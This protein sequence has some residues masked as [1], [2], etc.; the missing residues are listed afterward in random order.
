MFMFMFSYVCEA[1]W[2]KE[3]FC[4]KRASSECEYG[5][6]GNSRAGTG[7]TNIVALKFL[8]ER[9]MFRPGVE[10]VRLCRNH[11]Q[12]LSPDEAHVIKTSVQDQLIAMVQ[13]ETCALSLL[14]LVRFGQSEM[15]VPFRFLLWTKNNE[16]LKDVVK[17]IVKPAIKYHSDQLWLTAFVPYLPSEP[18]RARQGFQLLWEFERQGVV[19]GPT[20]WSP[21]NA[22]ACVCLASGRA[23]ALSS[24]KRYVISQSQSR[25]KKWNEFD[26]SVVANAVEQSWF[27]AN[28]VRNFAVNIDVVATGVDSNQDNFPLVESVMDDLARVFPDVNIS[29]RTDNEIA[30]DYFPIGIVTPVDHYDSCA[31]A[32]ERIVLA[33]SYSTEVEQAWL[34][35]FGSVL[36]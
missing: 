6:L 4:Y 26:F 21:H 31:E 13:G 35:Q 33:R 3:S 11:C 8:Q 10:S 27:L 15:K 2:T 32:E 5:L 17:I 14:G 29:L 34:S 28:L 18:D 7:C 36:E 22:V 24:P 20:P 23:C 12:A 19:I 1:C 30:C 9:G 25:D 16:W